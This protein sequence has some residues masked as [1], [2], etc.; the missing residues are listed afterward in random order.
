MQTGPK[1]SKGQRAMTGVYYFHRQPRG[2]SGGALRIHPIMNQA[3]GE[4]F[5]DIAPDNDSFVLFASWVPHEVRPIACPSQQWL[6]SR[7]SINCWYW[8]RRP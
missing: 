3:A 2:F 4:R 1:D 7:F 6:D 5:T 8:S